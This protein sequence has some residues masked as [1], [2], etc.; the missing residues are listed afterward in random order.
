[1]NQS[2][3]ARSTLAVVHGARVHRVLKAFPKC[4]LYTDMSGH[5]LGKLTVGFGC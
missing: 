4:N 1:M 5:G 3:A 2:R